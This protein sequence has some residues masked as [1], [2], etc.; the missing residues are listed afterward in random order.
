MTQ[1]NIS[2]NDRT[3]SIQRIVALPLIGKISVWE[4]DGYASYD[5]MIP[6]SEDRYGN[7]W[8]KDGEMTVSALTGNDEKI[9]R[10]AAIA[11]GFTEARPGFY[12][13]AR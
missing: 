5:H 2:F 6:E 8:I 10:A 13:V 7:A 1:I 12:A 3:T 9:F 4:D 11:A